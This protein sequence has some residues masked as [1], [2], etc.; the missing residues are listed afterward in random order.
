MKTLKRTLV[1]L[2]VLAMSVSLF[3]VAAF[4]K[5]YEDFTDADKITEDYLEAVDV[6]VG[7]G[8]IDGISD[9]VF[10][11]QGNF[12]REQAAKIIAYLK[13]GADAEKLSAASAPF[14]DV[15]ANSWSAGY[16]AYCAEQGII[17][18]RGDGTFDPYATL[19]DVDFAKMLLC[20]VGYG[21]NGEYTGDLWYVKVQSDARTYGVFDDSLATNFIDAA[22]REEC[23]LYAFNTLLMARVNYVELLNSYMQMLD[24]NNNIITLSDNFDLEW[25]PVAGGDAYSR[26]IHKW[27]VKGNDITDNYVDDDPDYTAVVTEILADEADYEDFLAGVIGVAKSKLDNN[28]VATAA[29]AVNGED[30]ALVANTYAAMD[31]EVGDVVELYKDDNPESATYGQ[32]DLIVIIRQ[33]LVRVTSIVAAADDAE[34]NYDVSFELWANDAAGADIATAVEDTDMAAAFATIDKA[35]YART[36]I[37]DYYFFATIDE[38]DEII[39]VTIPDVVN[40]YATA[41]NED[42]NTVT[43][44][45]TVYPANVASAAV[46][47]DPTADIRTD[48][49]DYVYNFYVSN[50]VII[51]YVTAEEGT[52]NYAFVLG[53]QANSSAGDLFGSSEQAGVAKAKIVTTDGKVQIVDLPVDTND[54]NAY[55]FTY[56]GADVLFTA[57]ATDGETAY[58]VDEYVDNE[59]VWCTYTIDKDGNYKFEIVDAPAIQDDIFVDTDV[60]AV[61][62][63]DGGNNLGFATADTVLTV[64][65]F[66]YSAV[67]PENFLKVEGVTTYTGYANFPADKDYGITQ[68]AN[69]KI[70]LVYNKDN[71]AL[72]NIYVFGQEEDE[73]TTSTALYTGKSTTEGADVYYQ[74]LVNGTLGYY[75]V[76]DGEDEAGA[77]LV[78]STKDSLTLYDLDI[79][80][81]NTAKATKV[82]LA[83]IHDDVET[84]TA[85]VAGAYFTYNDGADQITY[86]ADDC[87]VVDVTNADTAKWGADSIGKEDKVVWVAND[88]DEATIVFILENDSADGIVENV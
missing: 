39:D 57:T 65:P 79:A 29:Y 78:A 67:E 34:Y 15:P 71:T 46:T 70:L 16:I 22:T 59:E 31:L 28:I 55:V 7:I 81:D 88:D 20:A 43:V 45:G 76:E 4:A 2:L 3:S 25:V 41:K 68:D 73:S 61:K 21:V 48:S 32:I 8:V 74:F 30:A 44:N 75:I 64:V 50:G 80:S 87:I 72:T 19:T 33:D 63:A 86:L 38:N 69:T 52:T 24:P 77:A 12:T 54:A 14:T 53:I 5:D 9:T 82:A 23:V 18:G 26:E 13:L 60:A 47:A 27:Q 42:N 58:N 85:S 36:M 66:E 6:M 84:V 11:A 56:D 51:S 83:D 62:D 17:D 35:D 37:E 40:A 1:L 49:T 10:D